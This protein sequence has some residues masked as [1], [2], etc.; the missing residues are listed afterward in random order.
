[1]L[2]ITCLY[3]R[4]CFSPSFGLSRQKGGDILKGGEVFVKEERYILR[5]ELHVKGRFNCLN[6]EYLLCHI[7]Y[8][9]IVIPYMLHGIVCLVLNLQV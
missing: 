2:F 5:G 8:N 1:M 6:G 3:I 4:L 9:S 7:I